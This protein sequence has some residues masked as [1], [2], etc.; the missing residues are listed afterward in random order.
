MN[1]QR[2]LPIHYVKMNLQKLQTDKFE[3]ICVNVVYI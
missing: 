1:I 3:F 2:I